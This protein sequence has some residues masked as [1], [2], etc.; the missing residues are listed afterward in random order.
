MKM[1][2]VITCSPIH[3]MILLLALS[4]EEG[5]NLNVVFVLVTLPLRFTSPRARASHL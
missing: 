3:A 2:T 1:K 5:P 4:W